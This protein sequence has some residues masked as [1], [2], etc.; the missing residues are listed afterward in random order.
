M[1]K[2]QFQVGGVTVTR[3]C[4]QEEMEAFVDRLPAEQKQDVSNVLRA[5]VNAGLIE[6]QS[7]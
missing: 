6:I 3:L 2:K 4:S 7:E 1:A 5:L